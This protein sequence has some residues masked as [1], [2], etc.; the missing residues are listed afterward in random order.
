MA[1]DIAQVQQVAARHQAVATIG[2]VIHPIVPFP[3]LPT[4]PTTT[5]LIPLSMPVPS[6]EQLESRAAGRRPE[7]GTGRGTD[8]LSSLQTG[9]RGGAQSADLAR[10]WKAP[11]D[12]RNMQGPAFAS[13]SA[14]HR[15][16]PHSCNWWPESPRRPTPPKAPTR[17]DNPATGQSP[18]WHSLPLSAPILLPNPPTPMARQPASRCCL[19]PGHAGRAHHAKAVRRYLAEFL[20]DHRVVEIPRLLVDADPARHHPA[21]SPGQVGGQIRQHL[22]ARRL[23]PQ[24]LDRK[25]SQAAAGLVGPG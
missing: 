8:G 24:G 14:A 5:P 13:V 4:M 2:S 12:D 1:R 19:Q 15:P 6:G 20:S 3:L 17:P 18:P 21:L 11:T 9:S 7:P 10:R 16:A 22:D 23:A 25:A